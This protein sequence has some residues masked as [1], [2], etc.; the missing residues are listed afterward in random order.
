MERA[1]SKRRRAGAHV[2]GLA[3]LALSGCL[4]PLVDDTIPPERLFG[5]PS[6]DP[7]RA[8]DVESTPALAGLLPSF[9]RSVA[10]LRGW[11]DGEE[12]RY[13]NVDGDNSNV[14]APYYQLEDREG[15]PLDRPV[16]D[17]LPG[18]PGY[19]PW[20]RRVRVRVTERYLGQKLWSRE[21][22]VAAEEA[23]LV[24][25]PEPTEQVVNGPVSL[26]AV[27]VPLGD[28]DRAAAPE[29]IWYRGQRAHWLRF[30][31]EHRVPVDS[32]VMPAFPVHVL[33]RIDE[34]A[35]LYEFVTGVDLDGDAVLDHSNNVFAGGLDQPRYSPL[36]FVSLVRTKADYRSVEGGARP[37]LTG[38]DEFMDATGRV[39]SERVVSITPLPNLLVN[40]PIQRR[41]GEP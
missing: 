40:C 8:P 9:T 11:A 10:Y 36:W 37:E 5:A 6:L 27:R 29:P 3:G 38:E 34:G 25:T 16:I 18:E 17:V 24:E 33:Q 23:G 4:E 39:A 1:R 20:W 26:A 31:D 14:I 15:Q 21:A 19:T 35:P 12:V 32:Q 22:I 2:L 30:R 13:W 28:G 7:A 41:R